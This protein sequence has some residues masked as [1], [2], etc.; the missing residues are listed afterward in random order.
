M[1]LRL[2]T[3]LAI[4][5]AV[6]AL[7]VAYSPAPALADAGPHGHSSLTTDGCADCH[8]A[9]TGES[10]KLIAANTIYD[11]CTS[12]HGPSYRVRENVVDGW[13]NGAAG[14]GPPVPSGPLKGGG[15]V[16]ATMN[17]AYTTTVP[18]TQTVASAH[19]VLGMPGYT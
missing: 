2:L 14:H 6:A 8:R 16:N 19:Q 18:I 10:T 3:L 1:K 17:T 4:A 9:H 5:L 12:C 15:F 13:N 7:L 11:L